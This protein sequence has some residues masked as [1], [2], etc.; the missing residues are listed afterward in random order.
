MS[1]SATSTSPWSTK[2]TDIFLNCA[3]EAVTRVERGIHFR[4]STVDGLAVGIKDLGL[5]LALHDRM[6]GRL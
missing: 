5:L 6:T 2:A 3:L 1:P 4:L